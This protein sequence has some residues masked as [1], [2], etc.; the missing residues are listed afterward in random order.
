SLQHQRLI[1][2]QL[3]K[4]RIG[5]CCSCR[6]ESMGTSRSIVSSS[7]SP[8]L[9]LASGVPLITIAAS[10]LRSL[11]LRQSKVRRTENRAPLKCNSHR[12]CS[13]VVRCT[14]RKYE[15]V[16]FLRTDLLRAQH[17]CRI[18]PGV[19]CTAIGGAD[20]GTK[21]AEL[22]TYAGDSGG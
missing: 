9:L 7:P 12:A 22:H 4:V 1:D 20:P 15:P 19:T 10:H 14:A 5:H 11:W 17:H 6:C 16:I 8:P 3:F 21:L 2:L 13:A 18:A